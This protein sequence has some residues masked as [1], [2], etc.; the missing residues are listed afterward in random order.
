MELYFSSPMLSHVQLFYLYSCMK[1]KYFN[2]FVNQL[3]DWNFD[4]ISLMHI[5]DF[6]KSNFHKPFLFPQHYCANKDKDKWY[7]MIIKN[8][9]VTH[10]LF[11]YIFCIS[12]ITLPLN[13]LKIHPIGIPVHLVMQWPLVIRLPS[14]HYLVMF[15][16]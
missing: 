7:Q 13:S 16:T 1:K 15:G 5:F 8:N 2:S 11:A 4:L 6:M 9:K 3:I 10:S 14:I 12:F